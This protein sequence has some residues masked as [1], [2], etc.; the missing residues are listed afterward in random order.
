MTITKRQPQADTET[1]HL[2]LTLFCSHE[3]VETH[4]NNKTKDTMFE[5]MGDRQEAEC[6]FNRFY[7]KLLN[8]AEEGNAKFRVFMNRDLPVEYFESPPFVYM[9]FSPTGETISETR[10]LSAENVAGE[11]VDEILSKVFNEMRNG[12]G[13]ALML[14]DDL[15]NSMNL[16]ETL[17]STD[18]LTTSLTRNY[19]I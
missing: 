17:S 12:F 13:E 14:Y 2:L 18:N 16:S 15:I 6:L 5:L 8:A 11:E 19:Y 7:D 10:P 1:E 9:E 3:R 4:I